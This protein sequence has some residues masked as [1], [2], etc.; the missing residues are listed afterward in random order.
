MK[1]WIAAML[2]ALICFSGALAE[3][4]DGPA[5]KNPQERYEIYMDATDGSESLVFALLDASNDEAQDIEAH[6][7]LKICTR[8]VDSEGETIA[9]LYQSLQNSEFGRL[10]ISSMSG[11]KP[12]LSGIYQLEGRDYQFENG[13]L[14]DVEE[15]GADGFDFYWTSSHFPYGSLELLNG[16]RQD[17]SGRSYF[18]VKSSEDRSF[19]FVADDSLR[20]EELRIYERQGEDLVLTSVCEYSTGSALAI[21]ST[22]RAALSGA[23]PVSH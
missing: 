9:T 3:E 6:G 11:R 8:Y 1:K 14:V 19:E 5:L 7:A 21:P 17:E 18:L 2:G 13:A 23:V 16:V 20:I 15:T 10:I 22:I 4:P 12:V